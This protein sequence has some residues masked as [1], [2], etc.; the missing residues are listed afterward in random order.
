MIE[1]RTSETAS[2]TANFFF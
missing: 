2:N 1:K